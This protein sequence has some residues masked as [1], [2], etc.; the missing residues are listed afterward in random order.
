[1]Q[2]ILTEEEYDALVPKKEYED[3]KRAHEILWKHYCAVAGT[4][5]KGEDMRDVRCDSCSIASL[6]LSEMTDLQRIAG[7][8]PI[9]YDVARLVCPRG[10]EYSK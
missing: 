1:M 10:Q 2:Y 3:L 4:M 8:K 6:R 7:V 5:C 9:P